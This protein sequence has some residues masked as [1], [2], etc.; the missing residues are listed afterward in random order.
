MLPQALFTFAPGVLFISIYFAPTPL[1]P[2]L[3]PIKIEGILRNSP[4]DLALLIKALQ[5]LD[6]NMPLKCFVKT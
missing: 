2:A 5:D 1:S 3:I 4:N 6:W